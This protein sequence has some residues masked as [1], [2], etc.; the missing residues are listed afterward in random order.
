MLM[1]DDESGS[2]DVWGLPALVIDH[3]EIAGTHDACDK[4]CH[5]PWSTQ[6]PFILIDDDDEDDR[7]FVAWLVYH[8]FIK[9][10]GLKHQKKQVRVC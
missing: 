10:I 6:S 1:K 8:V 4:C 2:M 7:C 9:G 5:E 3:L